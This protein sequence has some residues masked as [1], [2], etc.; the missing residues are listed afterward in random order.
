VS[1]ILKVKSDK[2]DPERIAYAAHLIRAGQVVAIPTDTLYGLAADPFNLH[3]VEK[4]YQMKGRPSHKPLLLLVGSLEQAEDLADRLPDSFYALARRFWPGPL[5]MLLPASHKIPRKI[6]GNT[7]KVALRLPKARVPVA[8]IEELAMPLTGTS[9]NLAGL[10]GC[11]KA[12]EVQVQLGDR[13]PLILDGGDSGVA[14][15]STIVDLSQ[16]SWKIVRDGAIPRDEI[17]EFFEG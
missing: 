9:A 12:S 15:P 11:S 13:L 17:T 4:I 7:G 10:Q 8:L 14:V 3:A 2:P 1:E 5:T 16:K 6:T